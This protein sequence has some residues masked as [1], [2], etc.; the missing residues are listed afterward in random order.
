VTLWL[1]LIGMGA[2]TL[3]LRASFILL[4]E[5]LRLPALLRRALPFVPAAV[6]TAVWAPELLLQKGV[7]FLSLQNERLLAGLVAIAVSWRW[8]LTFA[9][10]AS[11]LVA[12]HLFDW[13]T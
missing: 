12:L 3:A 1:T 2:I 6:L 5:R 10:I 7:L 4:P 8:R 9:T 11:G 13:L